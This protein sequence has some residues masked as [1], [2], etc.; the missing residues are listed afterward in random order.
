M[1]RKRYL[2]IMSRDIALPTLQLSLKFLLYKFTRN[3]E[4]RLDEQGYYC[5]CSSY[6]HNVRLGCMIFFGKGALWETLMF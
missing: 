6:L 5:G 4:W 1:R 3:T 2:N